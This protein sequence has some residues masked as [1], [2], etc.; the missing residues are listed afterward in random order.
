MGCVDLEQS[1]LAVL[2][3]LVHKVLAEIDV[4]SALSTSDHVI[5]PLDACDVVLVDRGVWIFRKAH[6]FEEVADSEVD[7]LDD[8]F[9]CCVVLCLCC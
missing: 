4:L 2:D 5:S 6:V 7:H 9:G 8:H 1:H 3:C